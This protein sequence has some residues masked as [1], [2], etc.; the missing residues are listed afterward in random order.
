MGS[1]NRRA[2]SA[3]RSM[4]SRGAVYALVAATGAFALMSLMGSA[5]ALANFSGAIFTTEADCQTVNGNIYSDREAVYLNG[6][7]RSPNAAALP[8]STLFYVKVTEPDGTNLSSVANPGPGTITSDATGNLPCTQL[9]SLLHRASDGALVGYDETANPGGEYKVWV[10]TEDDFPNDA[11]KTDNFKVV[12]DEQAP[13][14]PPA[15]L[16]PTV[17]KDAAASFDRT[18]T[19]DATKSV[20]RTTV[21][22]VGGGSA[23]FNYTVSVT[24]SNGTDGNWQV[25]GTI[26]VS[27]PNADDI[28]GV[29]LADAVDNGGVCTVTNGTGVTVPGS[30]SAQRSYNC[31][32]ASEPTPTNGTNTVTASWDAQTLSPGTAVLAAG[33]ATGTAPFDFSSTAPN[34]IDECA[35]FTDTFNNGVAESLGTKCVADE[36]N[37]PFSYA[38]LVSVPMND[39]VSY[40]NSVDTTTGDTRSGDAVPADNSESV[41]VCGPAVTGA[42]TIGF[43]KNTNGNSLIG[44]YCAP[45]G[46]QSLAAYLSGLG[47]GSGPF[48]N[49]AGLSCG[50]LVTFVNNVLKGATATNMNVMLKAQMLATALDAYFTDASRG[51]TSTAVGRTKPPSAFLPN[52][53][54][55]AFAVDVT[56]VCPMVA[57]VATGTATCRNNTPSTDGVA[58]GVFAN[59]SMTV[60]QILTLASTSPSPFNGSSTASAWFGTD[61]AKQEV[62]KN[63]FDQINN[64]LAFAS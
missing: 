39:C 29:T 60:Q 24:H 40:P 2:P 17:S 3:P 52:K 27:N 46:K 64:Q 22:Q 38:R 50:Q 58:A 33:S 51:W 54:L 62:L 57:D 56:A 9:W 23:T 15:A 16:P 19:W 41:T 59:A 44:S 32:Y 11:S 34:L 12:L 25:G 30:G 36:L 55:G 14:D 5:A 10:S 48:S 4:S 20:D 18:Y 43:W 6:G 31:A 45:A 63:V 61:R 7:P 28:T 42:L 37:A 35:M 26:T 1:R 8:A 13:T 21:K 47:G 53:P 49:A